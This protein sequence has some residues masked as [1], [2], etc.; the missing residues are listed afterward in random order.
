[1][2]DNDTQKTNP[3]IPQ[4]VKIAAILLAVSFTVGIAKVG[5][6][7]AHAGRTPNYLGLAIFLAVLLLL[8]WLIYRGKNW[9]R[10]LFIVLIGAGALSLPNQYNRFAAAST[11][12]LLFYI[13][14]WILQVTAATLLLLPASRSYF[15][16]GKQKS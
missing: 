6:S 5:A 1:M 14:Q 3:S 15:K 8:A 16:R 2:P 13:L 12:T 7:A 10:W 4:E 11:L 9:A